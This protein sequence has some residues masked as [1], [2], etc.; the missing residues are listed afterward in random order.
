MRTLAALLCLESAI[1]VQ[2]GGN[3]GLRAYG[4]GKI[5]KFGT[6]ANRKASKQVNV[7]TPACSATAAYHQLHCGTF[8]QATSALGH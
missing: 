7:F 2:G 4:I 3:L 1:C 6:V 8:W 5:V